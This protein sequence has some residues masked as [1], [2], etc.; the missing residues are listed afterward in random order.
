METFLRKDLHEM[1]FGDSGLMD[2]YMTLQKGHQKTTC[3]VMALMDTFMTLQKGL[4]KTTCGGT[5]QM[6]TCMTSQN[7]HQKTTCGDMALMDTFMTLQKGH[8]KSE[9]ETKIFEGFDLMVTTMVEIENEK[10]KKL[11]AFT[12]LTGK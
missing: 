4:L 11:F 3:G 2:T 5:V 10:E 12:Y 8:Q 1:M 6:D 9:E 7:G